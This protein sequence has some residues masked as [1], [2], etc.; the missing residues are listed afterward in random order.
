M[1]ELD[2]EEALNS[3]ESSSP[4]PFP[5]ITVHQVPSS[6][7]SD[8]LSMSAL[9]IAQQLTWFQYAPLLLTVTFHNESRALLFS[10]CHSREFLKQ[11]WNKEDSTKLAPNICRVIENFNKV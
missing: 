8:I 10:R 7:P 3:A 11:A 5:G 1:K 9:E 4:A 6:G 2:L